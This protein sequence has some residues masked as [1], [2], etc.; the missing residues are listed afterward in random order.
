MS[1]IVWRK[2]KTDLPE[3]FEAR[4]CQRLA[5]RVESA[6]IFGSYGTPEFRPDSDV[7]LILVKQS[8][9]PFV[10]RPREFNDLYDLFPRMDILVYEP[11]ELED[12]LKESVGF[13]ASVRSTLRRLPVAVA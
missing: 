11:E 8:E 6:Y 10:E 7:D 13:W 4:L 3:D 2:T 1:A 12:L 5:G 9:R